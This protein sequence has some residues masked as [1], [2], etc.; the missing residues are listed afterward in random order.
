M[1]IHM[2]THMYMYMY[3]DAELH[4]LSEGT[5]GGVIKGVSTLLGSRQNIVKS[6]P[7]TFWGKHA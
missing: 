3:V 5:K 4:L 1:Y 7:S 2:Y 6:F